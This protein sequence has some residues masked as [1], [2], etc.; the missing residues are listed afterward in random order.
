MGR[1]VLGRGQSLW[2]TSSQDDVVD[3][4]GGRRKGDD[5]VVRK[6]MSAPHK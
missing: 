2:R 3:G 6:V 4:G 1:E 5:A